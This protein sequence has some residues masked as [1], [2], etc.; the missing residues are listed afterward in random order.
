MEDLSQINEMLNLYIRP[1]S[2]PVAIKMVA[3]IDE[4]PEKAR[5]PGRNLGMPMPVCQGIALVRRYAWT[6]AMG[7]E[8]M[9]CLGVS[10]WKALLV[11]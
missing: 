8:D 1:Q 11:Y 4:V 2:F 9:S 5:I 7:K 10:G 6:I 3:S